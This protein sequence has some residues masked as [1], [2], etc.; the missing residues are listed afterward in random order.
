MFLK[1][2]KQDVFLILVL[3]IKGKLT[4]LET[5]PLNISFKRTTK[6]MEYQSGGQ[7]LWSTMDDYL[8]FAKIFVDN[9]SSNGIKI[10][11]KKL[12]N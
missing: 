11:K 9:G 8:K 4:T 6:N 12:L 1:T 3:T 2:R 7:G 10:L 5:V